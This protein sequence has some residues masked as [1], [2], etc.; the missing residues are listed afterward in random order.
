MIRGIVGLPGNGK[1]MICVSK[2]I[3]ELVF[4][5]RSV[6][7]NPS[8]GEI[9]LGRLNEYVAEL[10]AKRAPDQVV[11]LDKRLII[12]PKEDSAQFYRYRSGGLIL[13][14]PPDGK[15]PLQEW[16]VAMKNYFAKLKENE[17]WLTPVSYF[18]FECHDF[19]PAKDW[20]EIGRPT[21]FY[22]SKHRH[23]HDEVILETQFPEQLEPNFRRLVQE[24]HKMT[25][26]YMRSF[27][28]FARKGCFKREIFNHMPSE[29]SVPF[30]TVETKLDVNGVASC[31]ETTG[32]LGIMGRGAESKGF[33]HKKKLPYW[34]IYAIAGA[35]ALA[36]FGVVRL[37][38]V[39]IGKGLGSLVGGVQAGMQS[40][41]SPVASSK[42]KPKAAVVAPTD[43]ISHSDTAE[44]QT[45]VGVMMRSKRLYVAVL[46]RGWQEVVGP[47]GADGI[48]LED[49]SIV[50]RNDVVSGGGVRMARDGELGASQL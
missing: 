8:E 18:I 50:R 23:L 40:R 34:T 42:E 43:R 13:P 2:M 35:V 44:F 27:G 46:N 39:L 20:Q 26:N 37:M 19:F 10:C 4:T 7:V 32:S 33:Q 48:L 38:P 47:K 45:V 21:K 9:K 15:M 12:I 22:A 31:Y 3:D 30:E 29:K 25:N 41:L 1:T 14:P 28:P 36:I 17:E 24:W 6:G 5:D 11:D 49:G 16:Y